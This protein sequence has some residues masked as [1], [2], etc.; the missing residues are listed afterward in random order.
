MQHKGFQNGNSPDRIHYLQKTL[1]W[2]AGIENYMPGLHF[3]QK[4]SSFSGFLLKILSGQLKK[5][6]GC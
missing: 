4:I 2:A 5:T 3:L 1:I 6:K